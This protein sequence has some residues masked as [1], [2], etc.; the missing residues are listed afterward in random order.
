MANLRRLKRRARK[1]KVFRETVGERAHAMEVPLYEAIR[2]CRAIGIAY[3][4]EDEE[5]DAL[6]FVANEVFSR[7]ESIQEELN[8][9]FNVLQD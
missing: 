9:L 1:A 3:R 6:A 8:G 7:L 4:P 5:M 2:L